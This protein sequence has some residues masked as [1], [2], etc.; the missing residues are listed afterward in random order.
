[1]HYL[2]REN[3]KLHQTLPFYKI[4]ASHVNFGPSHTSLV[5]PLPI[6]YSVVISGCTTVNTY[7]VTKLMGIMTSVWVMHY[8]II[9]QE[10]CG[11]VGGGEENSFGKSN[12]MG[13][14]KGIS[15]FTSKILKSTLF[16]VLTQ[17]LWQYLRE[18][19]VQSIDILLSDDFLITL[20]FDSELVLLR[21]IRKLIT[22]E[23]LNF[24]LDPELSPLND[25]T[26]IPC[27]T[28]KNYFLFSF[29]IEIWWVWRKWR[30]QSE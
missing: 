15:P 6:S 11:R 18:Y 22:L 14:F 25:Y 24:K 13:F 10:F 21:D 7:H 19:G 8:V 26:L 23:R 30:L 4:H 2:N 5:N 12:T 16:T 20:L 29:P 28:I 1:M 27:R 9:L 3:F 17:V